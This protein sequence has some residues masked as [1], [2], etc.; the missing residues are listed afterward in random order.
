VLATK[1]IEKQAYSNSCAHTQIINLFKL[2][3]IK[4]PSFD[5]VNEGLDL[6]IRSTRSRDVIGDQDTPTSYE[7]FFFLALT[8]FVC[9]IVGIPPAFWAE[10]QKILK[11]FLDTGC[12]LLIFYTWREPESGEVMTHVSLAEGYDESGY[13]VIDGEPQY[14]P[15]G[16]A[17]E[18]EPQ[19]PEVSMEDLKEWAESQTHG[20]RRTL[21][22]FNVAVHASASE[23]GLGLA[24]QVIVIYP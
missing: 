7:I 22:F 12:N 21:P 1:D 3:G 2:R 5:D 14:Y 10:P 6:V 11:P 24:A 20:S 8:D 4:P 19:M 9:G 18:L 23:R 16:A 13:K 15:E 17:I